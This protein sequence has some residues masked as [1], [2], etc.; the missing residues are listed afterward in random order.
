MSA[1]PPR[2]R[3]P[4][5]RAVLH[6]LVIVAGW[7][8]FIWFWWRVFG[9]PW[10]S[11]DLRLLVFWATLLFPLV[12]GAWILHNVGIYKR[13]GPRRAV[14]PGPVR[15]EAD[16]YGRRV[17]SDWAALRDVQTVEIELD[18]NV[19]RFRAAMPAGPA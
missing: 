17:D 4:R 13:R 6:A 9:Q 5:R 11:H 14:T 3:L 15:Y 18:G 19:K 10:E 7:V 16:F 12:T 1:A 8:V 2:E